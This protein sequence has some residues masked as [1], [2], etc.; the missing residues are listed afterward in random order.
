MNSRS[1]DIVPYVTKCLFNLK[2]FFSLCSLDWITSIDLTSDSLSLFFA[3][4]LLR[5]RLPS[6]LLSSEIL[7]F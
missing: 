2:I 6:K 4:S 1:F 3:T 5:L 7:Y